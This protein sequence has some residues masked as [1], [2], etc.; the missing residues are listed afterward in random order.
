M[1]GFVRPADWL[2]QLFTSSQTG[3]VNPSVVSDDVSLTQP[4]DGAGLYF[5]PGPQWFV[6]KDSAVG[7]ATGTILFTCGDTQIARVLAISASMKIA[8]LAS[9]QSQIRGP[10][11]GPVATGASVSVTSNEHFSIPS[12]PI[13]G[14]THQ[15]E[16]RA[17][18][19][20]AATV[21]EWRVYLVVAP[22]GTVFYV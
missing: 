5:T 2:R 16:G 12:I 18:G 1:S 17:F 7:A 22:L 14:P 19:G 20:G 15:L 8:T 4:Y 3:P 13:L 21:I 10:T 11:G 9:C 6:Q